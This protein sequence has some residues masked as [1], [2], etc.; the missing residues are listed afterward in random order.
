VF[1][2][3]YHAATMARVRPSDSVTVIGDGAVGLS[4]V[5]SAKRLG[6]EQ[7]I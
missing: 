7:I 5:L 2:T 1:P 4:A 3:G 6:A